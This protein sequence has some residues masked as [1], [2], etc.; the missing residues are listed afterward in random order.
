MA[1]VDSIVR[2]VAPRLVVEPDVQL[3]LAQLARLRNDTP[4]AT[5]QF[6]ALTVLRPVTPWSAYAE[7]ELWLLERQGAPPIAVAECEQSERPF[8]D[9][10]LDELCWHSEMT[11]I[12]LTSPVWPGARETVAARVRLAHDEEFLFVGLECMNVAKVRDEGGH[13]TRQRD[14][15]FSRHDYIELS[16]DVDRDY[17]TYWSLE[18]DHR[19]WGND[20]F[21]QN[22]NW[23]PQW[24][25][26]AGSTEREWT[27]EI[28]IP[29]SQ[30]NDAA[31]A[32]G[33]VWAFR[34]RRMLPSGSGT[35]TWPAKQ[36]LGQ[37]DTF[38]W[39][40]FE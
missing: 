22:R 3:M 35:Y 18:V 1:D 17:A 6:R 28:A 2:Q 21:G 8:L 37:E 11:V 34:V 40:R 25:V 19:G 10:V 29:F 4:W 26:A 12:E 5:R 38:G 7:G 32:A 30:L 36:R 23:D 33:D 27:C 13:Q 20:R 31:V 39:L 9:G 24:Y 16:I 14:T 15:D